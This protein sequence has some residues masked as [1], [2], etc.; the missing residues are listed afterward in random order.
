M[1][2]A[3]IL[4]YVGLGGAMGACSRHLLTELCVSWLGRGF[5]YGT[6]LVNVL[7]SFAMGFLIAALEQNF[8]PNWPLRHVVG[9]G[10]LGALTTF[11]T[12]SMDNL[13]L[14]QQGLW[15]KMALNMC[16]NL[17]V[18]LFATWCGFNLL[19]RLT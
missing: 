10:F 8:L 4:L 6:L 2:Q 7:G 14:L 15:L 3:V 16:L 11:S 19:T 9:L 5:P 1:S 17:F 18:C 12:F 13:L